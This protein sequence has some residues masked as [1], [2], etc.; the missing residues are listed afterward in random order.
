MRTEAASRPNAAYAVA[1]F[2]VI[3]FLA[4]AFDDIRKTSPTSDEMTHLAAGWSYLKTGDF[5]LNPEHPPLVKTLAALPL[6]AMRVW[7][8]KLVDD[9]TPAAGALIESWGSAAVAPWAQWF[10]AHRLF[11]AVRNRNIGDIA[12][13]EFIPRTNFLNDTER[14]FDVARGTLLIVIGLGLAA[15]IFLW[16]AEVWGVWGGVLSL[17]L[18]CF[19]PNFI[20]HTP[21]VTTDAMLSLL[22]CT[23]LYAFW[24]CCRQLTV[25]HAAVFVLAV[26]LAHVT[27][28]SAVLLWPMIAIVAAIAGRAK[29]ARLAGLAAS[30]VL[31]TWLVIWAAY[32]FTYRAARAPLPTAETVKT[33]YEKKGTAVGAVGRGV[34]LVNQAHLLPEAYLHGFATVQADA[35]Y[36]GAY[37]RGEFVE[38]GF[39]SYFFWTFLLKMPLAAIVAIAAAIVLALRRKPLIALVAL[40]PVVVYLAASIAANLNIGHRHILP[41]FP[42]LYVLCGSLGRR[43]LVAPLLAAIS[44]LT[45]PGNHIAYFNVL[46]GGPSAAHRYL[47]D[48]NLDWGQ[49]LERLGRYV[50]EHGNR[51][52][53]SL[54]Y[55]GAA[56]PRYYGMRYVN[57]QGGYFLAPDVPLNEARPGLFALS[58]HRYVFGLG[59]NRRAWD[60]FLRERKAKVV[61]RVG[62][63]M[64]VYRIE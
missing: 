4:L 2:C 38:G 16:S 22:M 61:T 64:M 27:K 62:K 28:F 50:Q 59:A 13:S 10:F 7:P 24:R 6:S 56:E 12:T 44:C 55:F 20:A 29:L 15:V 53:I 47:V 45:V 54:A 1:A 25:G 63:T 11:Y 52:P 37:L 17:A 32:G 36:R 5:R 18:F 46:A 58:I 40:T 8:E 33:W 14:I 39:R 23:A 34:L 31:V 30:A 43:W 51:E 3:A 57:L 60:A 49:D 41:I 48:S 9:G 19:D 21:L 42:F 35:V 26:G